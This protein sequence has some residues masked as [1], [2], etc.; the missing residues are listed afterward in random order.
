M[1][2]KDG[3]FTLLSLSTGLG[4][5]ATSCGPAPVDDTGWRVVDDYRVG[6]IKRSVEVV[7]DQKVS[8]ERLKLIAEAIRGRDPKKYENTFIGYHLGTMKKSGFWA[9]T[10]YTPKLEIKVLGLSRKQ[11]SD[12]SAESRSIGDNRRII[13]SWIDDRPGA[14]SKI[15]VYYD[16]GE[17][18]YLKNL[19]P[20][21]GSWAQEKKISATPQGKRLDDLKGNSFGEYYV[22]NSSGELEF[23]SR[24]G[25][26]YTARI[27]Q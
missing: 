2:Y 14:G 21:G 24:N 18:V 9:T 23:W 25:N 10:N 17:R 8:T 5:L 20:D 15:V 27:S 11:E 4:L 1:D 6:T 16:N 12:L 19:Y 26:Y 3:W 7:L 13:G 22:I